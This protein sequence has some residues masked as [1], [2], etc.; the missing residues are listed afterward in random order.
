MASSAAMVDS[1]L[2]SASSLV[3]TGKVREIHALD[4]TTLLFVT[5]D[6]ISAFDVVMK[7]AIPQKGAI[8]TL[9]SRFWFE[10]L[11]GEMP[12]L[13]THFIK[14]GVPESCRKSLKEDEF[15]LLQHRSMVVRRLKVL[16][17]ES[18]VRGYITG[19][20]WSS[21]KESE[22]KRING[23]QL[24]QGLQESQKLPKPLWTPSTKAEQGEH[25]ENI[26]PDQG[27]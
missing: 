23:I 16:P 26:S 18:I 3:A 4:A 7:N 21:Y 1:P 25:D 24:P 8:L 2:R 13:K 12:S 20:L 10:Y 27:E 19:S 14:V 11:S 5:T 22:D 6:R 17:L 9:L 15:A